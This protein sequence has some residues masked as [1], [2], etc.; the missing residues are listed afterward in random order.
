MSLDLKVSL[1]LAVDYK[2]RGLLSARKYPLLLAWFVYAPPD[3]CS[4]Q[5]QDCAGNLLDS[6]AADV[7]DATTLKVREL[8]RK[9]LEDCRATGRISKVCCVLCRGH[10]SPLSAVGGG[11]RDKGRNTGPLRHSV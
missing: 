6:S 3:V 2:H 11:V 7:H 9:E 4:P 1:E 10:H 5:R 8:F